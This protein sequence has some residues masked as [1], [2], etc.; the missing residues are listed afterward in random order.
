[1]SGGKESPRQKMIGMMYLVLTALLAMNISKDVLLAFITV[2]HGLNNTNE[3]FDQKNDVLYA[4]FDKAMAENKTKTKPWADKAFKVREE[5]DKLCKFIDEA[6]SELYILAQPELTKAMADTFQLHRGQAND[7]YDIP[8]NYLIGPEIATPT[9]KGVEIKKK[10][11]EFRTMVMDLV[12]EKEKAGFKMGLHTEDVFDHH[13]EKNVPWEVSNFDHT[14]M[15]ACM[16]LL[17]GIKNEVKNAESDIVTLL[18]R[19]I[20]AGDFKFDIV[21]AKVVAPTSYIVLGEEYTADIFVAAYSSTKNPDIS[22]GNVDT[23][24]KEYPKMIGVGTPVPVTAGLGK[25]TIKPT[26]EGMQTWGGIIDVKAPDGSTKSYPFSSSYMVARPSFAVS[27]TKMNVFYIG[28]ANPVS[29]SAAGV[30]PTNVVANLAGDGRIDSKGQGNY[31]VFV[32]SGTKCTINVS[33]KDPRTN[34]TKSMG[35]GLE[36]RIKKVPSPNAKFAGVIGDGAITK[37]ELQSA[38]GIFADLSDFVFDLKFPVTAWT[39]SMN[40]NG[41]FMDE[42]G[43]GPGLTQGMK[44]LLAKAKKGSKILIENVHVQAPDGDRKITGCNIKIK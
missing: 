20:D 9:G 38:G 26:S 5:A 24:S 23:T 44:A 39:I 11:H 34:S 1:M 3:N 30:A 22:V 17:A 42:S 43:K 18:L 31:E 15:A 27:P 7:N 14:T 40:V 28:V 25:Y 33:A 19:A 10:I 37:G 6:K 36:F 32:K 13:A 4:K 2:E 29:I 16:C 35:Q 12:P 41:L 8:T 21:T